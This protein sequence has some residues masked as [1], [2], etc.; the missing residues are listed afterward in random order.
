MN[1]KPVL[2][3]AE[4]RA[5]IDAEYEHLVTVR[6]AEVAAQIGTAADDGDLSE[7]A[8]YD[9]AKEEQAHIEGRIATLQHFRRNAVLINQPTNDVVALG[10]TVT[11]E[12]DGI[13]DT[14]TILGP[15]EAAPSLGRISNESPMGRAL[16]NHKTGDLVAVQ[17][18][19]GVRTVRVLSIR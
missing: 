1:D 2:L 13:H 15:F 5:L 7:N 11:I 3:T 19:A 9:H 17:A 8:A 12:E 14:Y 4:G 10:S 6:R 18:P 16:L